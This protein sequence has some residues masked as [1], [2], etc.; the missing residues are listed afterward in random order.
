[1]YIENYFNAI[2][3]LEEWTIYLGG[4]DFVILKAGSL[5]SLLSDTYGQPYVSLRDPRPV[6]WRV[7]RR[8]WTPTFYLSKIKHNYRLV[9]TDVH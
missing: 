3:L 6:A 9:K 5:H 8:Q 4:H 1:V 2:E 7:A